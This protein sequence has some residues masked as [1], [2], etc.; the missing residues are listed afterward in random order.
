MEKKHF[1][2]NRNNTDLCLDVICFFQEQVETP[3]EAEHHSAVTSQPDAI[4]GGDEAD[5]IALDV[6]LPPPMEIQPN[7]FCPSS[8]DDVPVSI[9]NNHHSN[10]LCP[11]SQDDIHVSIRNNHHSNLFCPSSQDDVPVSIRNNHHG[12]LLC[13]SSQDDVLVSISDNHHK[14]KRSNNLFICIDHPTSDGAL[15]LLVCVSNVS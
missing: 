4:N 13:P 1:L 6:E 7:L 11:S 3:S 15:I 5:E 12:N 14:W 8:Q 2:K 9:S 10:L